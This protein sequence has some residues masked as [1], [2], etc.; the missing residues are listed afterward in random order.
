MPATYNP[1]TARCTP[2]RER[3]G[4]FVAKYDEKDLAEIFQARRVVEIGAVQSMASIEL[5]PELLDR[6]GEYCRILEDLLEHDSFLGFGE[7]D[8]KFHVDLVALANNEWLV[9]MHRL[10]PASQ[11]VF[12]EELDL[13][14]TREA[15]R[16]IIR[17]HRGIYQAIRDR[18][19]DDAIAVLKEHLTLDPSLRFRF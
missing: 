19:I 9:K 12:P 8:R 17:D 6:L 1:T 5:D 3:G 2:T 4:F 18:R 10:T 14:A 15:G 11:F 16:D 13:T 7:I